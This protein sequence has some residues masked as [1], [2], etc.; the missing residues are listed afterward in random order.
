MSD[1][2]SPENTQ[3]TRGLTPE[4]IANKWKSGAESPNPSGRPK[5]AKNR[6][7]IVREILEAI[8]EGSGKS[9]AEASTLAVAEKAAA[10]DV[11]AWEKLM[12][13]GFGKLTEKSQVDVVAAIN[14]I[15]RTVIDPKSEKGEI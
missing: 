7:T 10:G 1:Q 8:H 9:Y 12:D 2:N 6:Q 11:T 14:K 5:G 13:S 15:E 4:M 3:D